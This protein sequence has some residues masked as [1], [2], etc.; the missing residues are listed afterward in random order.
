MRLGVLAAAALAA[1]LAAPGAR[2]AGQK[3]GGVFTIT[4]DL[5]GG[6]AGGTSSG[7]AESLT[8]ALGQTEQTRLRVPATLAAGGFFTF[9][10][11]FQK[12][13]IL[14]PGEFPDPDYASG[15]S[16]VA[17]EQVVGSTFPVRVRGVDFFNDQLDY[18]DDHVRLFTGA[19]TLG[20]EPLESGATEFLNLTLPTT[21]PW[22]L[23]AIDVDD[24]LIP[25]ADS[26]VLLV[27]KP[28]PGPPATT[29]TV[30][31]ST[32]TTLAG[33]L[34]GRATDGSA[35]QRVTV[36]LQD[37]Q[38]GQFLS[39]WSG[40]SSFSSAMPF[41]GTATLVDQAAPSTGWSLAL[42]DSQL[43]TGD[44]YAAYM[45]ALDPTGYFSDTIA[46]FTFN[47]GL[48][49]FAG[50][51]GQGTAALT[52]SSAKG[53]EPVQAQLSL[54][55]GAA[56]IAPG[57]AVAVRLPDGWQ[58]LT[59][60]SAASPPPAG[61]AS[62][63]DTRPA[64]STSLFVDPPVF[65]G[66]TLGSGWL[67][68]SVGAGASFQPG[69]VLTF[70][71]GGLPPL[72]PKGRGAQAFQVLE[73]SGPSG[74]L[75]PLASQPGLSL[76]E[77][78]T[79]YLSFVDASPLALGPDQ[80]SPVMALQQTDLCGNPTSTT[81]A[82]TAQLSAGSYGAGGFTS[83]PG[84]VFLSAATG[85]PI[86]QV[87]ITTGTGLSTT[88]YYFTTGAGGLSSEQV[89]AQASLYVLFSSPTL[90]LP[91]EVAR[92]ATILPQAL[93][94]TSVSVD[95]GP[96]ASGATSAAISAG[97]LPGTAFLRF[98]ASAAGVPWTLEVSSDPVSF[99]PVLARFSGQTDSAGRGVASWSALDERFSPPAYAPAGAYRLR[100][101]LGGG[102]VVDSSREARVAQSAFIAGQLSPAGAYASVQAAGPGAALGQLA[103]ASATGYFEVHGLEAGQAYSLLVST[104]AASQAG[105]SVWLSTAVYGVTASDAGTLFAG[106]IG[107]PAAALLRVAVQI[108]RPAPREA[109]G[110]VVARDALGRSVAQG[111][112]HFFAG[113][114]SSDDGG[115]AF[116]ASASTW[117]YLPVPP[118]SYELDVSLT[119]LGF[120]TAVFNAAAS[121][122][123]VVVEPRS[124]ALF[125]WAAA[126]S[127]A[128]VA[129]P[130]VLEA[131]R[132]G[133]AVPSVF[134][135]AEIPASAGTAVTST[136][137]ALY[138]LSVG[139]W[140]VTARS[141]ALA[142]ASTTLYVPS[143]DDLGVSTEPYLS[144]ALGAGAVVSGTVTVTGATTGV[145]Q[146]L[147]QASCPAGT[148][149]LAVEAYEPATFAQTHAVVRLAASASS[150]SST[151]TLSGLD[152]GTWLVGASLPGFRLAPSSGVAVSVSTAAPASADLSLTAQDARLRL[153][154][155]L[156]APAGGGCL[157]ASELQRLGVS[158]SD[159][160]G[161]RAAV[162]DP[163]AWPGAAATL[164][165]TSAT[166]VTPPLAGGLYTFA[167][168]FGPTGA[169]AS[170]A[171]SL[172]D[173]AT[174]SGALDLSG[175]T[176]AVSGRLIFPG[177]ARLRGPGGYA[178]SVSSI[179]GALALAP[180][181]GYCL[182]GSSD[183]VA[184]SALHVELLRL[185]GF[186]GTP[187]PPAPAPSSAG[188]ACA[189]PDAAA[190]RPAAVAAVAADGTFSF[191][192]VSPGSYFLRAPGEL[193]LDSADGSELA[194]ASAVVLVTAP[195]SGLTLALSAGHRVAGRLTLPPGVSAEAGLQVRL[196]ADGFSRAVA[197]SF[198]GSGAAAY[199][200]EAVPDGRY[201][202]SVADPAFP[203]R[204]AAAPIPV[205]TAGADVAAADVPLFAAGS[206]VG[207][208]ALEQ[209][210]ADG[211]TSFSLLTADD[212]AAWP[213]A[214][215]VGA[216]R[217]PWTPSG[218][219][220][221][222]A[223]DDGAP[224]LDSAGRFTISALPEGA[225]DVEL[226]AS[227]AP[228]AGGV[229]AVSGSAPGVQ[230]AEGQTVDLGVVVL[231]A[232]AQL[233]G[234]VL[235]AATGAPVANAR[236]AA[237]AASAGSDLARS[238]APAVET[239]SDG[240]GF[241]RLTG[242]DPL[243]ARFDVSA[244]RQ[245]T[246]G[247]A[248][249]AYQAATSF[250]IDARSTAT[251]DFALLPAE[252]AVSGRVA[253]ADGSALRASVGLPFQQAGA[254]LL[255]QNASDPALDASP[256]EAVYY[257]A[258]DGSF[259]IRA[260]TGAYRLTAQADGLAPLRLGV[261]VSTGS[262][263]IGTL[264]LSP[265]GSVFGALLRP[266]GAP[267]SADDAAYVY[268]ATPDLSDV[269]PGALVYDSVSRSVT[270]YRVPGLKTGTHYRLIFISSYGELVA[271]PE[272]SDLVVLSTSEA[273]PLD[274]VYRPPPPVA[275]A[276]ARRVPGGFALTFEL[277]QPLRR[278]LAV[279]DDLTRVLAEGSARGALQDLAL[280]SDRRELTA[281]YA[282]AV[283]ESSF[284]LTL[285]G[286]S[287]VVDPASAD[288]VDPELALA[289]T[290]AFYTGIDGAARASVPNL[291]GGVVSLDG[292]PGRV[293]LPAGALLIDASSSAVVS[294]ESSAG[295][296]A[297]S[298][299]AAGAGRPL[300]SLPPTLA[301]AVSALPAGLAPSGPFYDVLLPAGV[302]P[303]LKKP[304]TLTLGY[305]AGADPSSLN[306][307]WYNPAANAYVLQQD[308]T[309]APP[310]IDRVDR[311]VTLHVDHFSTYALFPAGA[312]VITGAIFAGSEI[313]AFNFP[314]PFD[315]SVKTVQKIHGGGAAAAA[316]IRGTMLRFALPAGASGPGEIRIFG[317]TGRRIRTI[318]LGELSGGQYYYQE[319]DGRND[320]GQ[321]AA[322]GVYFAEIKVGGRSKFVKMALIK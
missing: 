86:S 192:G 129:T 176:Y 253:A 157:A 275:H 241:Y 250:G 212:R 179:S 166:V 56:G 40:S 75:E 76:T 124:A 237:R 254:A 278:R 316:T 263:S 101:S 54:T 13:Q 23:S 110:A 308:V 279:D 273:R 10:F 161:A 95:T 272:A 160:S 74:T 291:T 299:S 34:T 169:S 191:P 226:N 27:V 315:L 33:A 215:R 206:I 294:L 5:V 65:D 140:T 234:R 209:V 267:A 167:A 103:Q 119:D 66:T 7:G 181:T 45:H 2:A 139:T 107:L 102:T 297:T 113:A 51:D 190:Y 239:R 277:S 198:D 115:Q 130:V 228:G 229:G 171:F 177:L 15:H 197:A 232:G 305:A 58:A 105:R 280:S 147:T 64:V 222:A 31:G 108:P 287:A 201:T 133:D 60:T 17:D 3:T 72:G 178:V 309:G 164:H 183:P 189:L 196:S 284:T 220:P 77:G 256:A 162:T 44:S 293:A 320:F 143:E 159:G 236:V 205:E 146:C 71:I 49:S 112:L 269:V 32:V 19:G 260:A 57:G 259:S 168:A 255:W 99:S 185:D 311:T 153:D 22:T 8:G 242:L 175:S 141:P 106:T 12:L 300:A 38:S 313:D 319:W 41:Y 302:R 221:A 312:S 314:N 281:F 14:L 227:G 186:S 174:T 18:V 97:G 46:T 317:V 88:F 98:A 109:A 138:G 117:T 290:A 90:S 26:S 262:I 91:A 240:S 188:G 163:S 142:S 170:K 155:L 120:S 271:P 230:V 24:V 69:D 149:E 285:Q 289:A 122:D 145:S 301:Q 121:T 245:E 296:V 180:T 248:E 282:P 203:P 261:V 30:A 224:V 59:S 182:L 42:P 158:Y 52:P 211:T 218:F 4:D 304:A 276:R 202:L 73:Q 104:L 55:V 173:G 235:D 83:D 144:L 89:R 187:S 28:S 247:S 92:P 116:G 127:S 68:A 96:L 310:V 48:L 35:V 251:L 238:R 219:F 100:L 62:L 29:L 148:F 194:D 137:F 125:G 217:R 151:F 79:S 298:P 21:G 118:G 25:T 36:A 264:T 9:P 154:V 303:A 283:G 82:Q 318:D 223:A 307:Y 306:A 225:Y 63:S 295:Y 84:A 270:G 233:R 53:C 1:A 249:A 172:V 43:K 243:A 50:S 288:P 156:P 123:V 244:G 111:T 286:Y 93:S 258:P 37:L 165:C 199:A 200:F 266:G 231:R 134:G 128:P 204:L 20:T 132:E 67:L 322:S 184:A 131:R 214:L 85:Q 39:D 47:P 81:T 150:V 193:D 246:P 252:F 135:S 87:D 126:P 292:D 207:R 114:A 6:S 257:T 80:F 265:A 274:V 136:T 208:L 210:L 268:A 321:D 152:A 216:A 61:A 78:T 16:G 213:L 70:S 11:P 195:A 94:L